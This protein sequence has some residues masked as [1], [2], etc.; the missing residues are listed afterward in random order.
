MN[1]VTAR[2]IFTKTTAK[3]SVLVVSAQGATLSATV[4]GAPVS[5]TLSVLDAPRTINGKTVIAQI[6]PMGLTREE[7]DAI[8]TGCCVPDRALDMSRD[9]ARSYTA[10]DAAFYRGMEKRETGE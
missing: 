6:G 10:E 5:A 2:Q 8:I 9:Y 7:Y 3:G 1:A 4:N